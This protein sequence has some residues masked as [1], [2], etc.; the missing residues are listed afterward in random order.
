[1]A[2]QKE[3]AKQ[4]IKVKNT[5]KA[6]NVLHDADGQQKLVGP[7]QEAELEVAEPQAK[8]LQEASKRGSPLV[9]DGHEPEKEEPS[10][11]EAAT[12]EEH[13]HRASLAKKEAELMKE[14]YE[15]DKDRREK[16]AKKS[17]PKLAAETG[18][19]TWARGVA[20]EVVTAPP[21]APPEKK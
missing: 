12:P 20:P 21:D 19:R 2:E 4:K 8:L 13:G 9:V 6:D 7:G 11:V 3:V 18:I 17:G 14:G 16:D 10:E 15:A 1:M 5:G